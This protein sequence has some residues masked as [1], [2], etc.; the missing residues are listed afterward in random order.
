M[1]MIS[2]KYNKGALSMNDTIFKDG[3]FF[4]GCN[5]WASHAG[6]NM[7]SDWR[8]DVVESDF[9]RLAAAK[10]KY[11]RVFPL[12][13]D[14]QPINMHLQWAG[15][16]KEIR[17]GEDTLPFTEAGR[18]GI[19]EVMVE[20]FDEF[21][22]LAEKYDMKLVIGLIT[23]W[24]SGR[25]YVPELFRSVNVLTDPKAI[26][27]QIKFV[28]Y[29]VKRFKNCSAIKA[30]DLGNECNCLG[31]IKTQEEAYLWTSAIT[32]AIKTEDNTRPVISGMHG[33]FPEST[34]RAEDLG[35]ILD[36][37]C[38]HP[39]PLFTPH[40]MTDP[41]VE[42]KSVMHAV[43][44]TVLYRGLSGK[45]AFAEE[46]GTLGPMMAS[47]E[48]A[49]A[50]TNNILYLLWA[51]DCK[52]FMWWCGF[53]Q[54][55]LNHTPYDWYV[56]ERELGL[57]HEDYSPKP[58]L[59]AMSDFVEF[60]E[61][62][63]HKKL[64]ERIVDAVCIITA[65]K[66]SW[67]SAYGTFILAKQAGLDIE[68]CY[69]DDELPEARAY[70]MPSVGHG[71]I[72]KHVMDE[73][74]KKVE[75]G[76]V[77]YISMGKGMLSS[78]KE[79]VGLTPLCRYN[80]TKSDVVKF[81][82]ETFNFKPEFK[83]D[84]K[85]HTACPIAFDDNERPVMSENQYGKGTIYYLGYAIEDIAGSVPGVMSGNDFVPYYKFYGKMDKLRNP[86]RMVVKDNPFVAVTEHISDESTRI[87]VVIN[88]VPRESN[89]KLSFEGYEINEILANQKGTIETD[90]DRASICLKPN[91]VV[92][93]DIKKIDDSEM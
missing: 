48:N 74:L 60:T 37:L 49:A 23:G 18:A 36:V 4:V 21:C 45:P 17:M 8:A 89:V 52:G 87:V 57:Y 88:S 71:E 22:R 91:S 26:K 63:K 43:A 29:M 67:L 85:V 61:K 55:N 15:L 28:K 66:G 79:I 10:V 38:T 40:C 47:E 24:M 77:L 35:E 76:A 41:I 53:E 69:M 11:L 12:W 19:S 86:E 2:E 58:V 5:Y 30:W 90:G 59:G 72:K 65:Q 34:F 92:I 46:V 31:Q 84:Y 80:P 93:F 68:F 20:R 51:H 78:F 75:Q 33:S 6:T 70:I 54:T 39:Y 73:L 56:F 32:M 7:W 83:V 13:S 81:E 50:Y 44:E 16:D 62:F 82:G 64:P 27:W 1:Q 25:L 9:K 42:N 3:E 14:F